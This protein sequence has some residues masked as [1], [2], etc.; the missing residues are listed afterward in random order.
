MSGARLWG[1][2]RDLFETPERFFAWGF[3]A[4]YCPL[5][6]MEESGRNL[7]PDKLPAA[8]ASR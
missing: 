5:V 7:T 8:N 3:V 2:W 1:L 6:F 4:N